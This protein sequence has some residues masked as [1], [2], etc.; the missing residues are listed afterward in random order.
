MT[1]LQYGDNENKE[2]LLD[3]LDDIYNRTR[4]I[5]RENGIIDLRN[6]FETQINDLLIS[7][8]SSSTNL[9]IGSWSIFLQ[10][11]FKLPKKEGLPSSVIRLVSWHHV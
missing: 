7:F 9:V 5:S 10:I 6:N 3:D 2:L 1:K 11:N 8:K 4:D